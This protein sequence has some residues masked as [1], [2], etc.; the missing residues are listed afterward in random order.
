MTCLTCLLGK[1]SSFD[2]NVELAPIDKQ[3]D[4]F[5]R[6]VISRARNSLSLGRDISFDTDEISQRLM[7]AM[8]ASH[9]LALE[10]CRLRRKIRRAGI[11]EMS[12]KE[13][14]KILKNATKTDKEALSS[15][16]GSIARSV[17]NKAMTKVRTDMMSAALA[18]VRDKPKQADKSLKSALGKTGAN[19]KDSPVLKT[20]FRTQTA[21]AYNAAA[22]IEN[23]D[24]ADLWGYQYT[25]AGDERVREEHDL[26]DGVR[27]PKDDLFWKVYAPPN[28]WNC[29][30]A[31]TPIY[32]GEKDA[33][34]LKARTLPPVDKSFK[35][36][37]GKIFSTVS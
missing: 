11:I 18:E 13:I 10:T 6:S 20:I 1:K 5:I 34:K 23:Q 8:L 28:G 2:L 33:R 27:Y 4:S 9:A 15:L 30:C 29:R 26:I 31:L 24:D 21:I 3:A 22:W 37:F 7:D 19:K 14:N 12:D 36:N 25:T 16:Y 17:T 32:K 35:T